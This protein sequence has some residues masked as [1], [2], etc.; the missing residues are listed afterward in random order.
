MEYTS[1]EVDAYVAEAGEFAR[2][3][4]AK[5]RR[6]FHEACPQI[7]E[8]MK[9]SYPHFEHR[10]LVGSMA[11]FKQHVGFG[12]TKGRLLAD[13]EG[14]FEGVGKTDM[15]GMKVKSLSD[16]PADEVLLGYIRQAV[17]L[18]EAGVKTPRPAAPKAPRGAPRELEVPDYFMAA[19]Q[20]NER[21]LAVFEGFSYS[22]RK[23]YVE[24][25]TEAKQEATRQRRLA[26][27]IE[28]MA[29]GKSRY[30]KYEK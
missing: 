12:F 16:L 11:A 24:W 27:A 14:L 7:R 8:T 18:N 6:L 13:P 21:A 28:W 4:L 30:A 3:I 5:I 10:G 23:E 20:E 17:A 26:T 19:L 25:V 29:E 15:S 1:P 9:W 22:H 2:P